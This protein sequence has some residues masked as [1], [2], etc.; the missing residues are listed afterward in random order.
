MRTAV[1]AAERLRSLLDDQRS[2]FRPVFRGVEEV[3]KGEEVLE[4]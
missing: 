3:I 1:A 4:I 2:G